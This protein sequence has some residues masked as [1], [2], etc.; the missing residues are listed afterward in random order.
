VSSWLKANKISLNPKKTEFILFHHPRKKCNYD[1]KLKIDGKRLYKS[2]V[3]KYLG[4]FLDENLTWWKQV[5]VVSNKLRRANGALSKLRHYVSKPVIISI[6]YALFQP[7]MSYACQVW[8]LRKSALSNR[9]FNLQKRAVRI[10]S[11]SDRIA[12]CNPIYLELK[13]LAFY[14]HVKFCSVIFIHK[15]IN[16]K[17]PLSMNDTFNLTFTASIHHPSRCKSGLLRLPITKT[18]SYGTYSIHSQ[19]VSHWN[20]FQQLLAVDDIST[21]S[22]KRFKY[23]TR[24]LIFSSY[25]KFNY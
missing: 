4:I 5:E 15:L 17:L 18:V 19:A 7:H 12:H 9:V 1:V 22:F 13:I 21:L 8:G 6:Y 14:D 16:N 3:I 11:F 23:L 10:I 20:H 24:F 25:S 2:S